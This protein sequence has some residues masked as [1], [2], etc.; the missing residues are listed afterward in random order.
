[1]LQMYIRQGYHKWLYH[2]V[3]LFWWYARYR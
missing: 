3:P 2:C 1:M